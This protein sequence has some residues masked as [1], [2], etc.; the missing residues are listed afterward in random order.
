MATPSS[1]GLPGSAV[2]QLTAPLELRAAGDT[3][4]THMDLRDWRMITELARSGS[5]KDPHR[6]IAAIQAETRSQLTDCI[7]ASGDLG[8]D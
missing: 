2:N 5:P 4:L 6:M 7:A 8:H 1:Q 3:S